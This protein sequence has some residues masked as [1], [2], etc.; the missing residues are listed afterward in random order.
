MLL[1]LFSYYTSNFTDNNVKDAIFSTSPY[2]SK[3]ARLLWSQHH[4]LNVKFWKA[5]EW[6]SNNG[7][8]KRALNKKMIVSEYI[9]I[10][11]SKLFSN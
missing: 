6:P 10:I 2:H 11:Y 1:V 7:F 4:D 8:F 9:S 5:N 3:R